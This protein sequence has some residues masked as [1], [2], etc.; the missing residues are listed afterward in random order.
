MDG[1]QLTGRQRHQLEQALA[2]CH[3]KRFYRRLLALRQI[4]QGCSISQTAR[5]LGISRQS[6]HHWLLAYGNNGCFD[7]LE[8]RSRSGRPSFWDQLPG[9][10]V[11]EL[12]SQSPE[13]LGYFAMNWTVPLLAEHLRHTVGREPSRSTLRR[14]LHTLGYTWKRPRYVLD[15]DPQL[16]KKT[17]YSVEIGP[18]AAA[19]RDLGGG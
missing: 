4:D 9:E 11:V 16:E 10:G 7:G 5:T 17:P 3:D 13:D 12:L 15:P 18:F 6:I 19:E 2:R 1:I 8:D 14:R